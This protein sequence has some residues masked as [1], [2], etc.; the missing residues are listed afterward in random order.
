MLRNT[1]IGV[2]RSYWLHV[3]AACH[4]GLAA[5]YKVVATKPL[6]PVIISNV[7]TEVMP[8]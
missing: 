6:K 4:S 3:A 7:L 5:M 2:K 1:N 8:L